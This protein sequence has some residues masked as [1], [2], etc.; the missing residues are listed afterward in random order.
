MD[1]IENP[2]KL[3][4]QEEMNKINVEK[5]IKVTKHKVLMFISVFLPF[6]FS[7]YILRPTF[8]ISRR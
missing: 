2:V 3:R 7:S 6:F 1:A 5:L 8:R 4:I